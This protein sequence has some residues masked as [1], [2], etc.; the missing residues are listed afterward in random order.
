V[1][2]GAPPFLTPTVGASLMLKNA[3]PARPP[4]IIFPYGSKPCTLFSPLGLF[5]G[6]KSVSI[7]TTCNA[8]S[9]FRARSRS[10]PALT[11]RGCAH[12]Y[13]VNPQLFGTI[14]S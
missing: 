12:F 13:V 9:T 14:T 4:P 7:F 2:F 5:L 6:R 3:S 8:A 11:L 1:L 10:T